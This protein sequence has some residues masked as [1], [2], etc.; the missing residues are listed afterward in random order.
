MDANKIVADL[1]ALLKL[2]G[3]PVGE[4]VNDPIV[5]GAAWCPYGQCFHVWLPKVAGPVVAK[6][7]STMERAG[8]KVESYACDWLNDKYMQIDGEV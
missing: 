2:C 3:M 8:L 4:V 6:V 1:N 7:V 5:C